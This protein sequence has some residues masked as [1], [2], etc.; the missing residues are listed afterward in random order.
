MVGGGDFLCITADHGN[1]PYFT[2]TDHTREKV[3]LLTLHAPF[4]LLP[5]DDFTQVAELLRRYFCAQITS[6]PAVAP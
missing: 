1:D 2:G 3:P 5:S 4:P 6:L